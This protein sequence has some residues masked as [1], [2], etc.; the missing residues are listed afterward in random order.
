MPVENYIYLIAQDSKSFIYLVDQ[1][2]SVLYITQLLVQH[3][4]D[5]VN[6]YCYINDSCKDFNEYM[7]FNSMRGIHS[8][9]LY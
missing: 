7:V 5:L 3:L 2:I 1:Y 9:M 4:K 6:V 8:T